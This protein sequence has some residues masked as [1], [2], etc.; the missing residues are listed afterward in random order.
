MGNEANLAI[1]PKQAAER[2]IKEV[3]PHEVYDAV[4]QLLAER[5]GG[6]GSIVIKTKEIV[7][8]AKKLLDEAGREYKDSDFDEKG[9]LDFEPFYRENGWDVKYDGPA[10][11]ESYDSFFKF[12]P[13]NS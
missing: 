4:N 5:C 10:Y 8:L 9:W 6:G 3:I 7:A 12:A 11:N 13:K 1:T 2:H